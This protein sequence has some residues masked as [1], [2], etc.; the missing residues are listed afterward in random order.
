M[1]PRI[2]LSV[3]VVGALLVGG[4]ATGTT[5]ASW[6]DQAPL[7][8]SSITSG[9]MGFTASTPDAV[10]LGRAAGSVADATLVVD[11]TSVGKNL[12]QRITASVAG[13]P[14][15]TTAQIGPTCATA[16]VSSVSVDTTPASAGQTLCVRVTSSA[17]AASGTVTVNLSGA[18]LP[19]GWSTPAQTVQFPVTVDVQA[20]APTIRCGIELVDVGHTFEWSAVPAATNYRIYRSETAT[21]PFG[22][23]FAQGAGL[24]HTAVL[25]GKNDTYYFRVTAVVGEVESAPSNVL[26][27]RR[28]GNSHNFGCG[29]P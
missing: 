9:S 24:S 29:A 18:Q 22:D 26:R 28:N 6:V 3:A 8:A 2:P 14:D 25:D 13:S 23:A 27:L 20:T 19:T 10:T 17:T 15:G 16:T 7:H 1:K 5:R 21:G 12:R 11:D 4:A